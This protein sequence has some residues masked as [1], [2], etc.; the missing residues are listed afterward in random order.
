MQRLDASQECTPYGVGRGDGR[1]QRL[2]GTSRSTP[3][4][5]RVARVEEARLYH[6]Y[7]SDHARMPRR[8][9]R[10]S[11]KLSKWWLA[12]AGR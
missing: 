3:S 2:P 9:R 5:F 8:D 1:F 4:F 11:H 12:S 6:C 10:C 7:A